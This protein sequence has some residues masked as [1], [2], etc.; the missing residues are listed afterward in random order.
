[1][2]IR[3]RSGKAVDRQWAVVG[4]AHG[5]GAGRQRREWATWPA[6]EAG[7]REC[8]EK[9]DDLWRQCSYWAQPTFLSLRGL[10]S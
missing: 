8:P 2:E 4:V 1:M 10:V 6:V 9:E 5:S 7:G 3:G